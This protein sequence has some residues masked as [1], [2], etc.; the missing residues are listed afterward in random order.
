MEVIVYILLAK[1]RINFVAQYENLLV[2]KITHK[3]L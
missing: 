2:T 1:A 3:Y